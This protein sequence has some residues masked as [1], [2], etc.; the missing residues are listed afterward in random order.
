MVS[1]QCSN[2]SRE[3]D[4][5]MNICDVLG[6]QVELIYCTKCKARYIVLPQCEARKFPI[7]YKMGNSS[8]KQMKKQACGEFGPITCSQC[9]STKFNKESK[10]SKAPELKYCVCGKP[11]IVLKNNGTNVTVFE[12]HKNLDKF[13][14]MRIKGGELRCSNCGEIFRP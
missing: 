2:L 6:K 7:V 11:I 3:V 10:T 9:K 8:R 1:E 12:A 4:C 14:E 13:T 5:M